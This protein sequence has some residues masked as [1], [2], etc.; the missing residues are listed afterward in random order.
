MYSI[1]LFIKVHEKRSQQKGMIISLEMDNYAKRITSFVLFSY[2]G[3][4]P[5][6][7]YGGIHYN[8]D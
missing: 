1:G 5:L 6:P 4:V 8:D 7:P 2:V 3:K